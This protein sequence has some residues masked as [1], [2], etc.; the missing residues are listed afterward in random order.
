MT[1]AFFGSR[2][3]G[4]AAAVSAF[5]LGGCSVPNLATVRMD[6]TDT[7]LDRAIGQAAWMQNAELME[8]NIARHLEQNG[9]A[10]NPDALRAYLVSAGAT[11][12]SAP[13]DRYSCQYVRLRQYRPNSPAA[14]GD[15]SQEWTITVQGSAQDKP[16]VRAVLKRQP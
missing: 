1:R 10:Q 12:G 5:A 6:L 7:T 4:L 2:A 15:F 9:L 13:S 11:C 16:K 3:V 8:A 14:T